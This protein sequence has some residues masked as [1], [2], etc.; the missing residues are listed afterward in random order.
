MKRLLDVVG[1]AVGL[2]VTSPLFLVAALAVRLESRGPVIFRQERVGRYGESFEILKFRTMRVGVSGTQVTSGRDPRITRSGRWLR[3]TKLDELP[4]LLNVVRGEMSLVGPRPEVPK[5][6][7]E[8]PEDARHLVLSVRPGITD[9]ASIEFRR[10]AE[11]L[12]EADDPERHYVD[13]I[14]PRKVSLYCDYVRTRSFSGD[15]RVIGDTLRS[16]AKD[17]S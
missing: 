15:L 6:V 14:L 2:V 11:V 16:V 12:A 17:R 9:P 7:A 10:E 1:A 13:V 3:S 5:Y 8:W 4:Q